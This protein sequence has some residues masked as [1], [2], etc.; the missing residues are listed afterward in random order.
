M[1]ILKNYQVV[2]K[3]LMKNFIRKTTGIRKETG[4][5]NAGLFSDLIYKTDWC[6]TLI[7]KYLLSLLPVMGIFIVNK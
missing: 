7:N 3:V 5:K 1:S 6:N 4:K 2:L